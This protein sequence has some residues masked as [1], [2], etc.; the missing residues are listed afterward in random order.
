MSVTADEYD[1]SRSSVDV[2]FVDFG[3]S[4]TKDKADVCNLRTDYL[5]LNFQAIACTLAGVEP[6]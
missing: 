4:D 3:D 5:K 1:D 2:D 6:K